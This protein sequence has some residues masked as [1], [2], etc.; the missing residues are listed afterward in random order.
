M[1]DFRL[2]IISIILSVFSIAS[3]SILY[4]HK[5]DLKESERNYA[6]VSIIGSV[7]VLLAAS[8]DTQWIA[9]V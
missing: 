2:I 9:V 3:N 4:Q 7:L 1:A 5:D 8:H 6:L